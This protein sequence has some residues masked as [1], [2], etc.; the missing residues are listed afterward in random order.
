MPREYNP[1]I[2]KQLPDNL[3]YLL[4]SEGV[5]LRAAKK[6]MQAA[7]DAIDFSKRDDS[8]EIQFH[9]L[10]DE[11]RFGLDLNGE[12]EVIETEVTMTCPS[13]ETMQAFW[14]RR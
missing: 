11:V 8:K 7:Q 3:R 9:P 6:A 10:D 4:Q 1:D 12:R 2:L 13:I 14:D 5:S